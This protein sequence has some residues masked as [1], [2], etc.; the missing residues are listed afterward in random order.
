MLGIV[1]AGLNRDYRHRQ[2]LETG[3]DRA[4]RREWQWYRN[5]D[6]NKVI[7]KIPLGSTRVPPAQGFSIKNSQASA[8]G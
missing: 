2:R 4:E 3:H 1:I 8:I 7:E 5:K 6:R